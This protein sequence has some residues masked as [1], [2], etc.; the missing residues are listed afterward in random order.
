[1]RNGSIVTSTGTCKGRS[2]WIT[3]VVAVP[4][5]TAMCEGDEMKTMGLNFCSSLSWQAVPAMQFPV[6]KSVCVDVPDVLPGELGGGELGGLTPALP[7][8]EPDPACPP[9]T[10]SGGR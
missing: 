7:D 3:T 9:A 4:A 10:M 8:P 2:G 6:T 1:M 5:F